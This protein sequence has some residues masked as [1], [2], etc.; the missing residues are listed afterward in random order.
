MIHNWQPWR[1]ATGPKTPNG[2]AKVAR[3]GYKGAKRPA[4]RSAIRALK[5]AMA[6]QSRF[7]DALDL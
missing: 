7:V 5:Y 2:K 6:A 4:L 3:N 1:Q